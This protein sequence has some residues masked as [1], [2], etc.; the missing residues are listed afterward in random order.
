MFCGTLKSQTC[1]LVISKT[2]N[3]SQVHSGQSFTYRIT[4]TN[5]GP[6][7]AINSIFTDTLPRNVYGVVLFGCTGSGGGVC[8]GSGLLTV[9]DSF[10]SGI[11]PTLPPNGSVE[12]VITLNA[13]SPPPLQ[14]SFTNS[15]RAFPGSGTTDPNLT[16][17]ISVTSTT[18]LK[19]TD[20]EVLGTASKDTIACGSLSDSVDFTI[21]WINRGLAAADSV[22]L[23]NS[24]SSYILNS[25]GVGNSNFQFDYQ[26]KNVAWNSSSASTSTP[27]ALMSP[28]TGL[29]SNISS[30]ILNAGSF[31]RRW[32]VGD[33]IMLSYRIVLNKLNISGCGITRTYNMRN[34]AT[35][36]YTG[37][38]ISHTN[39]QDTIISNNIAHTDVYLISCPPDP[40]YRLDIE[41]LKER[42]PTTSIQ[43]ITSPQTISYTVKWINHGPFNADSIFLVDRIT[44][45]GSY[46]GLGTAIY[47]MPF[48]I[49]NLI[50][51]TSSANSTP[52]TTHFNID[53]G[54]V[55]SNILGVV[56]LQNG[57]YVPQ[58]AP[59]DTITLNYDVVFYPPTVSGCGRSYTFNINNQARF[60]VPSITNI[61]DT[62]AGNNIINVQNIIGSCQ[63]PP[64]SVPD[65]S[66]LY[67]VNNKIGTDTIACNG[68]P[69]SINYDVM[70]VNNG[71][72]NG[73]GVILRVDLQRAFGTF[74]NNNVNGNTALYT[75]LYSISNLN[76]SASSSNT[77]APNNNFSQ[78]SGSIQSATFVSTFS[79]IYSTPI[80]NW[81]PGD[82]IFLRYTLRINSPIV[83]GCGRNFNFT[84]RNMAYF[85]IPASAM[86]VDTVN[87]NDR[88]TLHTFIGNCNAIPCEFTDIASSCESE[89]LSD[90]D[91]DTSFTIDY[92]AFWVNNGGANADSIRLRHILNS[93]SNYTSTGNGIY[94]LPFSISNLNWR[95]S[96]SNTSIPSALFVTMSGNSSFISTGLNTNS[97]SI[98]QNW[99]VGDTVH[100]NYKLTINPNL[101]SGCGRESRTI[102]ISQTTFDNLRSHLLIDTFA[103]NNNYF[104]RD[105]FYLRSTDLAISKSVN[106]QVT[107]SGDTVQFEVVFQNAPGGMSDPNARWYD[108]FPPEIKII[109]SSIVCDELTGNPGCGTISYDSITRVLSQII[110]AMPSNSSVRVTYRAVLDSMPSQTIP[111]KVYAYTD[112]KDCVPASNFS[113]VNFQVDNTLLPVKYMYFKGLKENKNVSLSWETVSEENNMGFEIYRTHNKQDWILLGFVNGLGTSFVNTAYSFVDVQPLTFNYY[114]LKQL[115]FDGD[116][117]F[118][119]T[120][121]IV[122][123]ENEG[124]FSVNAYPNPFTNILFLDFN[125]LF[126][127]SDFSYIVYDNI[128]RVVEN[129]PVF[130]TNDSL[131]QLDMSKLSTGN[132]F[133]KFTVGS[134][135]EYVKLLKINE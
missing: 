108:T 60:I 79:T 72:Y 66:D 135:N 7:S 32:A 90:S 59:G 36:S 120:I 129:V 57:S 131:F 134:Q 107:F 15:A 82:T 47:L 121:L 58:W 31:V 63:A 50:W 88:D 85:S 24:V 86:L 103:S 3:I 49:N 115:D 53:T 133:V 112:C 100:L 29:S 89:M 68:L 78:M 102:I 30:S 35:F 105:T 44:N 119:N 81:D 69:D 37:I 114:R 109:T 75:Y 73:A 11:V 87:Y 39:L 74:I 10:F 91:C 43:C 99:A 6:D 122:F 65:S 12:F 42:T 106:P 94:N 27:T 54:M 4:I 64:C 52:P 92:H 70:W 118:S 130:K 51:S 21:Y 84:L 56:N 18:I 111:L 62:V 46:T 80:V 61:V 71:V 96:S 28:L 1:D 125:R 45:L 67:V 14:S 97:S 48:K 98:V 127:D 117:H 41:V 76:W 132:Y 2:S 25:S 128:G 101:F 77:S 93:N 26:I 16:S 20:I 22:R 40:C 23:I 13:P 17:N 9:T 55:S 113:Q 110:P 34:T 38:N 124:K 126:R 95:T 19:I 83:N 104:N 116:F 123:D 8:P 33:T 5:L